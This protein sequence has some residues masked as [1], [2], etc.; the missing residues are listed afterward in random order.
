MVPFFGQ[1]KSTCPPCIQFNKIRFDLGKMRS[2]WIFQLTYRLTIEFLICWCI[3][4]LVS[5]YLFFL[6]I[7]YK[8]IF[9]LLILK[10]GILFFVVLCLFFRSMNC[11][12]TSCQYQNFWLRYLM[13]CEYALKLTLT[14]II[15]LL[16]SLHRMVWT[17][18]VWKSY[19]WFLD[20]H[21]G[22]KKLNCLTQAIKNWIA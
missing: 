5:R 17:A 16:H 9:L 4:L 2:K 6:F 12:W 21:S 7:T 22:S 19:H 20:Q 13:T 10:S 3:S 14:R 18:Y 1:Q 11:I 15:A 8:T